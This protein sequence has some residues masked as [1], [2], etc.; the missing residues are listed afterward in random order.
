MDELGQNRLA[1][2]MQD[3]LGF[4]QDAVSLYREVLEPRFPHDEVD[5]VWPADFEPIDDRNVSGALVLHRGGSR[6][7][8]L[9]YADDTF[10][11]WD[12]SPLGRDGG[13]TKT[14]YARDGLC[15]LRFTDPRLGTVGLEEIPKPLMR[16]LRHVREEPRD[17][18]APLLGLHQ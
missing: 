12:L 9:R 14:S 1:K 18:L 6:L 15:T 3:L 7:S 8:F 2:L 5:E 11:V 17:D 16:F 10:E 13:L 4:P